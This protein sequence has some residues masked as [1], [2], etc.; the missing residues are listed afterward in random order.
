MA[1]SSRI[2]SMWF[3]VFIFTACKLSIW[4]RRRRFAVFG[5]PTILIAVC[6]GL[7]CPLLGPEG[8]QK[9]S[10]CKAMKPGSCRS[11]ALLCVAFALL[12]APVA[13]ALEFVHK[14]NLDKECGAV[15]KCRQVTEG[16]KDAARHA[17]IR[18]S[19]RPSHRVAH[20]PR[21]NARNPQR[22]CWQGIW[23]RLLRCDNQEP[24]RLFSVLL[25]GTPQRR[26]RP[27][28]SERCLGQSNSWYTVR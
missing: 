10:I 7:K 16:F 23:R 9:C 2:R 6:W 21:M 5:D 8:L 3:D 15:A 19:H 12:G 1:A 11:S 20:A 25:E 26:A 24:M 14:P 17:H 13:R 18:Q 27:W 22:Y 28:Y 4:S